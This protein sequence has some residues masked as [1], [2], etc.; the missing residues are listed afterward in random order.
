MQNQTSQKSSPLER[1]LHRLA[2]VLDSVIPL[3]GNFRLGVDSLI[4][5]IPGFGDFA[6]ALISTYIM[7]EGVRARAPKSVLIRM[8]GN[9]AVDT[10]VGTVPFLGDIFDIGFRSNVRN[11]NL[12]KEYLN[13]PQ[14]TGRSSKWILALI[15]LCLTGLLVG[16]V[17]LLFFA[18]RSLFQLF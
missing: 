12:L 3:P 11:V 1:R 17:L 6:T 15:V 10:A 9:V 18:S 7:S 14:E 2:W 5:L 13:Q 8:L 4:G 16:A